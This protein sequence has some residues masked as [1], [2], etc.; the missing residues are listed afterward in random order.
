MRAVLALLLLPLAA[1]AQTLIAH[2]CQDHSSNTSFTTTAINTNTANFIAVD[3]EAY[4]GGGSVT[5]SL[6]DSQSNTWHPLTSYFNNSG[7]TIQMSYA[8]A[9]AVGSSHTFTGS[10]TA[11]STNGFTIC[12]QAWKGL[13][14]SGVF[15]SG[16][17]QGA[18]GSG[19]SDTTP[20]VTPQQSAVV[21]SGLAALCASCNNPISVTNGFTI[22][23]SI[24]ITQAAPSWPLSGMAYNIT[25]AAASTTWSY[26]TNLFNAVNIAVFLAPASGGSKMKK[27]LRLDARLPLERGD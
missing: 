1:P 5:F 19:T 27:L 13:L 25:A 14:A 21:I 4:D 3:M 17:D 12:V 9:A 11:G 10:I 18:N 6:S 24:Q 16:T 8:Q 23:D 15:Q 22:S 7:G 2:T 20:T 26:G